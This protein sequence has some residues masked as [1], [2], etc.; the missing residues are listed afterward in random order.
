MFDSG[1]Q[2]L[3]WLL[4]FDYFSVGLFDVGFMFCVGCGVPCAFDLGSC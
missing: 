2:L 4:Q 3:D 1:V